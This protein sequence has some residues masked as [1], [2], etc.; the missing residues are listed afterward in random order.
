[1]NKD[2]LINNKAKQLYLPQLFSR[3]AVAAER[4]R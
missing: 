1:M 2:I 4:Y 3:R